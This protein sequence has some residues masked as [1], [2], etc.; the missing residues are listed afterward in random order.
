[1][2]QIPSFANGSCL[3]GSVRRTRPKGLTAGVIL[4][5]PHAALIPSA[6]GKTRDGATKRKTAG[7][8]LPRAIAMPTPPIR[9]VHGTPTVG[10]TKRDA[11]NIPTLQAVPLQQGA[12]GMTWEIIVTRRGAGNLMTTLLA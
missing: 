7:H 9:G 12:L 8:T 4:P 1:M 3:G 2:N 5:I 11:G 10:A 6:S